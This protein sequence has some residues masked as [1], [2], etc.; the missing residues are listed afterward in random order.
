MTQ[1]DAPIHVLYE[2][3]HLLVV[4]KPFGI[5]VQEDESQDMDLLNMLKVWLKKRDQKQG[6]VYLGLVHRLDRVTG[7]VMV[8]AKT[9]KAAARLSDQ[10]RNRTVKKVY[11]ALLQGDDL[12]L[13]GTLKDFLKKD[14][15]KNR[16]RVVSTQEEGKQA[17]LRYEV[18]QKIKSLT[19]VRVSLLTGRSH[20]IRVQFSSRGYPIFGDVKYGGDENPYYN[21]IA[22]WASAIEFSHPTK[23]QALNI[24][25][26][27]PKEKPWTYFF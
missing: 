10:I 21:G 12:L 3:N 24:T 25:L 14:A 15:S 4:E 9:S 23:K 5:P 8:F 1:K 11:F 26:E 6:N 20:Q 13:D 16:V 22:L 2:D 27:K 19:L 17:Q 18:I 7:G